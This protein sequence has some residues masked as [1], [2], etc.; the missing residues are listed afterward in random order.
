MKVQIGNVE[1]DLLPDHDLPTT[2]SG[3]LKRQWYSI[4]SMHHKYDK[5]CSMC[6][7]GQWINVWKQRTEHVVYKVCPIAWKFF[8]N[9]KLLRFTDFGGKET[10]PFPN[11]K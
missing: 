1:V 8:K 5:D 3:L 7:T 4:C 2:G 11:L 10:D 9:R 6:N